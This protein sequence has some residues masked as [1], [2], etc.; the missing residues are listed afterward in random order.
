MSARKRGGDPGGI[1]AFRNDLTK[2]G[3]GEKADGAVYFRS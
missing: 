2:Q 3:H 1:G